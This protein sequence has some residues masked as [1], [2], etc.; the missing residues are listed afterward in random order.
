MFLQ[1]ARVIAD[2]ISRGRLQPGEQLPSSRS[3]AS[4]LGVSRNTVVAAYDELLSQGW[5]TGEAARGTFVSLEIPSPSSRRA[6]SP[7]QQAGFELPPLRSPELPLPRKKGLLLLLGGVPEL[8]F[9]PQA[10]LARAYRRTLGGSDRSLLDYADPRGDLRLRE[11]LSEV[12]S[13]TRGVAAPPEAI[14]VVRGSQQGVYLT[15]RALLGPGDAVAVESFGYRHGWEA[16]R[17]CGA[18][19]VSVPVDRDGLDVDALSA[20]AE[21]RSIRAVYLTPHHQYP[22]TVTM[23]AA[24][25]I[26]LLELAKKRRMIVL[27]DDYDHD[28]HYDGR[29]VLP[30]ASRDTSG[31]VIYLGT[32]SKVLAPG[33]R[34]GYVVA[35][36][37]VIERIAAYRFYVDVQ[38]DNVLERAVAALIEDGELQKHARRALRAYRS[39]RD[40]LC[41]LLARALPEL[42]FTVPAGGMAVW[43][44]APGIN[45]EAW[46]KRALE[47]GV[48][49]QS[50]RR[51]A[52][53][54]KPHPYL[55]LGFAACN[56]RELGEAVRRLAVALEDVRARR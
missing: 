55:R 31:V 21:Q 52:F 5:I 15:A 42:R 44:H 24:R 48:A 47:A 40:T 35:P 30:L 9:L 39:R 27:E 19:L 29:P 16:L 51:F 45:V 49:I 25:R 53:D 17:T 2:D 28:F 43:A 34:L 41:K 8:R 4:S 23:P 10:A 22:T 11:A 18:E 50:A 26:Q 3:L 13:R 36:P 56:E 46:V 7:S 32:M 20:I 12:L 6:K 33:L 38:G 54:G 1:I 14:A 37:P